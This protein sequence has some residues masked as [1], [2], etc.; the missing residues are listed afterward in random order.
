LELA[1]F[2]IRIPGIP[3]T[4][5]LSPPQNLL[6]LLFVRY[7]KFSKSPDTSLPIGRQAV[8]LSF[9]FLFAYSVKKDYWLSRPCFS[10]PF[11]VLADLQGKLNKNST[12]AYLFEGLPEG[13]HELG[14]FN[15]SENPRPKGTLGKT[16]LA[17]GFF[18]PFSF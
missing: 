1:V 11:K 15:F 2:R 7:S 16:L 6:S 13:R 3:G 10:A 8:T 17:Q 9:L 12:S 14:A 4:Q 18:S 5:Y